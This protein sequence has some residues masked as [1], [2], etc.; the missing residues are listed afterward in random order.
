[1]Q[2]Y[3][4]EMKLHSTGGISYTTVKASS[5]QEAMDKAE[6]QYGSSYFAKDVWQN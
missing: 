2:E 3:T 1:M 4:V 5:G 6:K